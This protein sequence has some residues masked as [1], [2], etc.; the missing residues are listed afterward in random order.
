M[1]RVKSHGLRPGTRKTYCGLWA[2]FK[3]MVTNSDVTC[4]NCQRMIRFERLAL[5]VDRFNR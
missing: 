3:R 2:R 1:M 4:A 5:A